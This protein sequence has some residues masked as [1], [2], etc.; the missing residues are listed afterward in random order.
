MKQFNRGSPA[1]LR[2]SLLRGM[3]V[4]GLTLGL[5]PSVA[6]HSSVL[7]AVLFSLLFS[8]QGCAVSGS[9]G[10]VSDSFGSISDS[11]GSF[12]DSS[13]S[14]SEDETAYRKDIQTFTVAHLRAAGTPETL[15]LGVSEVA[16][17]RGITDWEALPVTFAAVGA[18]LAEADL[19][20]EARRPY[21][22]ALARPGTPNHES[23][24]LGIS[25]FAH[26]SDP[27]P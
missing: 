19:A 4:P 5:S 25:E 11:L 18:G 8:L 7:M 21:Q 16:L 1:P 26:P 9:V 14:S 3:K 20:E 15:R 22:T 13:T 2:A 6:L 17:A 23:I 27:T 24:L 10:S 12:S